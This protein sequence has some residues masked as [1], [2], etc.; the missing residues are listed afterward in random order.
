M[1]GTFES[2]KAFYDYIP[3]N[4]PKPIAWGS[5]QSDLNMY[6]YLA[7]YHD[8]ID[9]TPD[10]SQFVDIVVKFHGDSMGKAPNGRFG[11]HV[12]THLA[13]IPNDNGWEDTWEAFYT[14]AMRRMFELEVVS[15]GSGDFEFEDLKEKMLRNVIPR[16]LRPMES[17]GRT[18]T[19]C[20]V[21]SDLWLGNCMLDGDTDVIMLFDS[22][23]FW[24]HNEAD[25][26]SWRAQ[27]YRMGKPFLRDYQR[28]MGLSYPEVRSA[29]L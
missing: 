16:L 4:V 15:H 17:G 29:S 23:A 27:R 2:E 24:G 26:G 13:N 6:F 1:E 14:K 7:E 8:M 10:S 19:P 5:Y 28:K 21:H 11:F 3:D 22:C 9:E 12:P 25:L 18:V 20:L